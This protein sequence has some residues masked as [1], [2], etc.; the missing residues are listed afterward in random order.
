MVYFGTEVRVSDVA[1]FI[2]PIE[3]MIGFFALLA[4]NSFRADRVW[5][6]PLPYGRGSVWPAPIC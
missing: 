4:G 5:V 1:A 3:L 2:V 6:R